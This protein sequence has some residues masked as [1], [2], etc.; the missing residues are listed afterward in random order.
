MVR[1]TSAT[2]FHYRLLY[3]SFYPPIPLSSFVNVLRSG[4]GGFP[5][6][7][8]S[9][10]PFYTLSKQRI[11]NPYLFFPLSSSSYRYPLL[12]S[13]GGYPS[14]I[15][16]KSTNIHH[17]SSSSSPYVSSS[18]RFP[19]I[20]PLPPVSTLSIVP[21]FYRNRIYPLFSVISPL[22]SSRNRTFATVTSSMDIPMDT[23]DI[24]S[25]SVPISSSSSSIIPSSLTKRQYTSE[26][27]QSLLRIL[28]AQH[29][30]LVEQYFHHQYN[31]PT[32]ISSS[33]SICSSTATSSITLPSSLSCHLTTSP[34]GGSIP[35]SQS[36]SSTVTRS[37]ILLPS[38]SASTYTLTTDNQTQQK[39]Q[40]LLSHAETA[41]SVRGYQFTK[42]RMRYIALHIAYIGKNYFGFASQETGGGDLPDF[43]PSS[44]SFSSASSTSSNDNNSSIPAVPSYGT[45]KALKR[46]RLH[47]DTESTPTTNSSSSSSSPN[48]VTI[49]SVVFA[50]LRKACLI[51]DRESSGY[52][53]CGRTDRGVSA[54]GQVISLRVRS[55]ALRYDPK[56][57]T[58]NNNN[59][60]NT[61]TSS[62]T[63]SSASS[64]P[65]VPDYVR[66]SSSAVHDYGALSSSSP[67][68]ES[69]PHPPS[70]PPSSSLPSLWM[71]GDN[72]ANTGDPFPLPNDENDY[73]FALNNILPP[74]IKVLGWSDI[75]EDFSARFSA[76]MRTYRYY[77][78]RRDLDLEAMRQASMHLVGIHD[79]RN[80]CKIDVQN[81]QNFVREI[82]SIRIVNAE[83]DTKICIAPSDNHSASVTP[84]VVV[85][86]YRNDHVDQ[87]NG[88]TSAP[89]LSTGGTSVSSS[90]SSSSA[91]SPYGKLHSVVP[92]QRLTDTVIPYDQ[93]SDNSLS[94]SNPRSLYYIEVVGRAF[95]WHQIRCIAGLLFLVGRGAETPRTVQELLDIQKFPARPTYAMAK[96]D[97]LI[98]YHCSFG[99][100]EGDIEGMDEHMNDGTSMKVVSSPSSSSPS[101]FPPTGLA[102]TLS[103]SSSTTSSSSSSIVKDRTHDNDNDREKDTVVTKK[104]TIAEDDTATTDERRSRF[105]RS[106]PPLHLQWNHSIA[107]L[108]RLTLDIENE[109]SSYRIHSELLK[110]ILDR[111]YSIGISRSV[112]DK[113][114]GHTTT[115]NTT[116][117][118]TND[119]IHNCS[120]D[121]VSWAEVLD[122]YSNLR[123]RE[124][125][126]TVN[127]PTTV[128]SSLSSSRNGT[129]QGTFPTTSGIRNSAP[130]LPPVL[131]SLGDVEY[132]IIGLPTYNSKSSGKNTASSSNSTYVPLLSRRTGKSVH[133]KW[134]SL[135]EKKKATV[136]LIHPANAPKLVK[137]ISH[138]KNNHPEHHSDKGTN[139][140]S[141]TNATEG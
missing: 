27:A 85:P 54:G 114:V 48:L 71:R 65:N 83:H 44:S 57:I 81:T 127:Q 99:E 113:A 55:K 25:T 84:S 8:S 132:P 108:R 42:Y 36:S 141:S 64:S 6:L 17:S 91:S 4:G 22:P 23:D 79:Y 15:T 13:R 110:S 76:T 52:T 131:V 34:V 11:G 106:Y 21:S 74:D 134:D 45:V 14:I 59:E 62:S 20:S 120:K 30:Q 66:N 75:P 39:I 136:L 16:R 33:S 35:S 53:R 61:S 2:S 9:I 43:L 102:T 111:I 50:T 104:A 88:C 47:T 118:P 117:V 18:S 109:W 115:D 129:H 12:R 49:E 124:Y 89:F 80:I 40:T 68:I 133:E 24:S 139:V 137:E 86:R 63:S 93:S 97:P 100:E 116:V 1:T 107:S 10:R 37:K 60:T 121:K 101:S 51:E 41:P 94:A 3:F 5:Y 70:P 128:S 140:L 98:L 38:S 72:L 96:E 32:N 29:P 90:T 92:L 19:G 28:S 82:V 73:C 112:I 56:S 119:H 7:I 122:N 95:L 103:S 78:V 135:S 105:L 46:A 31:L 77:F 58:T 69:L 123:Y 130:S 125:Q 26:E 126:D 87:A 138:T 67:S